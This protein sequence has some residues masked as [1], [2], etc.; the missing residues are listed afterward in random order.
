ME[1]KLGHVIL[2]P[3]EKLWV[4]LR[5]V[6][7]R[8]NVEL[9]V[10]GH[11]LPTDPKADR[12]GVLLPAEVLPMLVQALTQAQDRLVKR[13]LV[14]ITPPPEATVMEQG[15]PVKLGL[16]NRAARRDPRRHARVG[17]HLGI[18][19]RVLDDKTFWPGRP[20]AGEV[21]DMS[22]GGAQVW[23]PRRLPLFAQL[24]ITV[25]AAGTLFRGRGEVVGIEVE[26]NRD[27]RS[28]RYRHGLRWIAIDGAAREALSKILTAIP[29]PSG[30]KA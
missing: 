12:H 19:C 29:G 9:R 4:I 20:V 23:L 14:Y 21:K 3:L 24:E 25:V 8:P 28:G 30:E 7:G 22:L 5:D 10:A 15:V 13:G 27:S 26:T 18:E 1:E 6:H 11:D 17:V 16:D 2:S